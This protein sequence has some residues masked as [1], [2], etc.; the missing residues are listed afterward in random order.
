MKCFILLCF[1]ATVLAQSNY[2]FQP[3]SFSGNYI[4]NGTNCV[5]NQLQPTSC[6]PTTIVFDSANQRIFI[7]IGSKY[8]LFP[9]GAYVTGVPQ[10]GPQC[11]KVAN[12]NYTTQ[13]LNYQNARLTVGIPSLGAQYMGALLDLASCDDR[14][15]SV[16]TTAFGVLTK[17][18][19]EQPFPIGPVC[20]D[21]H[22]VI[23]YDRYDFTSDRN[24]YFISPIFPANCATPVDFCS[25]VYGPGN[26]C[27]SF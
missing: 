17:W 15:Y 5:T 7:D 12:Y 6:S 22:G 4:A 13:F 16:F 25:T 1:I 11:S 14:L 18:D 24:K 9:N 10:L 19:F 8:W 23:T 20:L 3:Y 26:A 2:L 21:V 27:E